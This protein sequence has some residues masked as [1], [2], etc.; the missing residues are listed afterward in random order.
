MCVSVPHMTAAQTPASRLLWECERSFIVVV[1]QSAA[2]CFL[3]D[4][5]PKTEGKTVVIRGTTM[6][7]VVFLKRNTESF[8]SFNSFTLM[9]CRVT[10]SLQPSTGSCWSDY[11]TLN[12]CGVSLLTV[13][14]VLQFADGPCPLAAQPTV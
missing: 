5:L 10:K 3:S 9:Y 8:E 2:L 12:I 13:A 6:P 14:A 4:L 11:N 1:H 7:E